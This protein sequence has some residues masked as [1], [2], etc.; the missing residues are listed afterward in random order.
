[1]KAMGNLRVSSK[2][3]TFATQFFVFAYAAAWNAAQ[4]GMRPVVFSI[5]A[6]MLLS[7]WRATRNSAAP[8]Y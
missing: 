5:F 1:M 7:F 2:N 8:P 3:S 4:P 6:T